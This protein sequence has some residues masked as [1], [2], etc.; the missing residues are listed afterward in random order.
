M[1][2]ISRRTPLILIVGS[3]NWFIF[4]L[5]LILVLGA[6]AVWWRSEQAPTEA[7]GQPVLAYQD[8]A[9]AVV[10]ETEQVL[11]ESPGEGSYVDYRLQREQ[12]RQETREMLEILLISDV[13]EVRE[14]AEAEWLAL[15]KEMSLESEL[16]NVLKI[17]GF[18]D[19]IANIGADNVSVIIYAS[20]LTPDQVSLI[21]DAVIRIYPVRLDKIAIS[22][23][24]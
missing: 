1:K 5:A 8:E 4:V 23:M 2:R 16:E 13:T 7:P 17:K 14:Q 11:P 3:R 10:I 20:S 22:V 19:V 12:T 15:A 24:E 6:V 21:Q 18:T 9:P